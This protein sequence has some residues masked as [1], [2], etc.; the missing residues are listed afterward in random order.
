VALEHYTAML[1]AMVLDDPCRLEDSEEHYRQVWM[2]HALEETEHKAVSFDVWN[3]VIKPGPKR[4]F[5]RIGAMLEVTILFWLMVF[6]FHVRLL[7]ADRQRGGHL[8]GMW[9]VVR[10]L[11]G[12]RGVFPTIALDWLRFFKPSFHPWDHDNR[13]QLAR[14]DGLLEAIDAT[15]T[16]YGAHAPGASPQQD[17]KAPA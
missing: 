4:Y 13:A 11:F 1:A 16:P 10:F 15:S 8:R 12:R 6:E 3:A 9:Q 14:L 2:W 17:E 7:V 5:M